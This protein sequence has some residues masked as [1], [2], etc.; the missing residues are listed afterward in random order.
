MAAK[1]RKKAQKRSVCSIILAAGKGT[2]IGLTK[3]HKTCLPVGGRPVIVR[4]LEAYAAAGV[5]PHVVVVGTGAQHVLQTVGS[6]AWG[7]IPDAA[8]AY[9]PEP[10][11]TGNAAKYGVS[12]LRSLDYDGDILVVAGDKLVDV[13][14][15]REMIRMFQSSRLDCL[16][17]VGPRQLSPDSGR[18]IF[19]EKGLPVAVVETADIRRARVLSQILEN[20]D[21]GLLSPDFVAQAISTEG[22]PP[23]KARRAFGA[24]YDFSTRAVHLT[25]DEVIREISQRGTSFKVPL[26]KRSERISPE[27]ADSAEY[28]NLSLYLVKMEALDFAVGKIKP[29]NAQGEEYLT[30]IVEILAGAKQGGRRRFALATLLTDDPHLVMGFNNL[31]ELRVIESHIREKQGWP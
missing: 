26:G 21:E 27:E 10:L 22:L 8:F 17:L 19:D 31:D 1:Q 11:G 28:V 5:S 12:V 15:V 18:V 13:K 16:L 2:R 23:E 24:L 20:V 3:T 14:I 29:D 30:D 25:Q 9:Q 7:G 6:P 4:S